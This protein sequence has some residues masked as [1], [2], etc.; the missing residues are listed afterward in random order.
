MR[1]II[2]VYIVGFSD[3][4]YLGDPDDR[5]STSGNVLLMSSGPISWLS[6]KQ[7]IVTL[8]TAEA[9]YVTLSIATQEI[10]V[11]KKAPVRSHSDT[12]SSNSL[13]GR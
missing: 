1:L 2:R 3:A 5:H 7:T 12:R 11:D 8:S 10:G 9:E 6:K 4:D 13:H